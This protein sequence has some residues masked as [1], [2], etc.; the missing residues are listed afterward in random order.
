MIHRRPYLDAPCELLYPHLKLPGEK[1]DPRHG[2]RLPSNEADDIVDGNKHG[3]GS[4]TNRK[5]IRMRLPG[6]VLPTVDFR[7]VG[8]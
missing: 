7:R 4:A 3:P 1:R 6:A 2:Q 8:A 5:S